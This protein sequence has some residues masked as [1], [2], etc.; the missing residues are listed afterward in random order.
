MDAQKKAIYRLLLNYQLSKLAGFAFQNFFVDAMQYANPGFVPVK[1]Q[2]N[3]GDWK[4]D[5]H[6]PATGAYFQ[7]Y[8]PEQIDEGS[9]I[10]KLEEDFAGLVAKWSDGS[11]YPSGVKEFYFVLN[12]ARRVV[13]GGFPTTIAALESLKQKHGLKKCELFLKS[14]VENLVLGLPEDQIIAL[15]GF[16]PNPGSIQVLSLSLINEVV[17]HIVQSTSARSLVQSLVDPDFEKKIAFN[18]LVTTANWLRD[19][20]YRRGTL[21]DYFKANGKFT[22]QEVRDRLRAIYEASA[23]LPAA[24]VKTADERLFHMLQEIC[25]SPQNFDP[26]LKREI[27][28][29]ALVIVAYFFESCDVFEEPIEC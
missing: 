15:V 26:R 7:I 14:D 29:A 25:P 9:A 3:Q 20:D 2:G 10:K 24:T 17:V 5:G 19:A 28:D 1:P 4:N 22:R 8:S 11:V 13:L 27:Q 21:E 12:D 23:T 6:D 16:P 18:E